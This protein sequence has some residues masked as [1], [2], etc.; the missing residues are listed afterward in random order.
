MIWKRVGST[1]GLGA[2]V[3]LAAVLS[4]RVS[5]A[6]PAAASPAACSASIG[7][8]GGFT[9]ARAAIG[10]EALDWSKFAVS[11]FNKLN[12]TQIKLVEGDIQV[13][14]ALAGTVGQQFAS[15]SSIL[16]VVG[17]D[18][19]SAAIVAGPIFKRA[20]LAFISG[21]ATS[22]SL[23]DGQ[24]PTFFRVVPNDAVQAPTDAHFM[25]DQ[26]HAKKVVLVDNQTD[27]SLGLNTA[28]AKILHASG[29]AVERLSTTTTQTDFSSLIP[30]IGS[31]VSVV[32]LPLE[33]PADAELFAQQLAVQGGLHATIFGSDS[34]FSPTDFHPNGAYVSSFAPD[35]HQLP[36]DAALVKAYDARYGK[37]VT[38]FGP[39][40][41]E[42]TEVILRAIK[43]SCS[44][45]TPTRATVLA[46]IRKTRIP[47]SILG[48][49]LSFTKNGEPAA[50]SFYIYKIENGAYQL[51]R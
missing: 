21:S 42:A 48:G 47:D 34:V 50:A 35:I 43:A 19:S 9:G 27:Y 36:A 41:Y 25:I 45:G 6:A 20:G 13:D 14:P 17:P 22:V 1:A 28:I 49:T 33:V 38:P 3:V 5:S 24:F 31:D 18:A 4:A 12:G 10:Q 7:V 26:L 11:Q 32:F 23:T 46:G 30:K 16:G 15:D 2:G 29:V 44:G 40:V 8:M 37:F 51:V 39:P